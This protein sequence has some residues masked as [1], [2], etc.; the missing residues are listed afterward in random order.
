MK[1]HV[2][3]DLHTEFAE[4]SPPDSDAD[5]VVL[6]GDIGAGLGGP[7]RPVRRLFLP[8]GNICSKPR[9]LKLFIPE[10]EY[11]VA[12]RPTFH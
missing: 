7:S 4:F 8:L 11:C 1:L 5:V 6:A 2:L 12:R 3:G 10:R 9:V